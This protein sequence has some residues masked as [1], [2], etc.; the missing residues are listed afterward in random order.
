MPNS[1]RG[2]SGDTSTP[3]PAAV[4]VRDQSRARMNNRG[5]ESRGSFS[6]G[7]RHRGRPA[8]PA[9]T[10]RGRQGHQVAPSLAEPFV[11]LSDAIWRSGAAGQPDHRHHDARDHQYPSTAT[12]RR[13]HHAPPGVLHAIRGI[14][15]QCSS[16]KVR[17]HHRVGVAYLGTT[18]RW[19]WASRF[20]SK[21]KVHL[22]PPFTCVAPT[23]S[24]DLVVRS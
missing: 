10:Q 24:G 12:N 7:R 14:R 9:R 5:S 11:P 6:V 22:C 19:T 13:A 23:S 21:A 4:P 3:M 16:V 20:M 17:S 1:H 8:R 18:W 15:P 2:A